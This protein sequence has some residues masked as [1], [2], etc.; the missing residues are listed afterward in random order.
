LEIQVQPMS[1]RL[2]ETVEAGEQAFPVYIHFVQLV[3][4][5]QPFV[6][7]HTALNFYYVLFIMTPGKSFQV[8]FKG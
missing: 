4:R 3:E 2:R 7:L 6:H 5:P 8:F 1:K